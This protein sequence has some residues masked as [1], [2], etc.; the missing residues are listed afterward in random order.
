[1][2]AEAKGA[3]E[4]IFLHAEAQGAQRKD[5]I[6]CTNWR[7]GRIDHRHYVIRSNWLRKIYNP[8][9]C[10][11]DSNEKGGGKPSPTLFCIKINKC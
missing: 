2:H 3:E 7:R 5:L 10:D 8:R 6:N 11:N 4:S 1:M 9:I